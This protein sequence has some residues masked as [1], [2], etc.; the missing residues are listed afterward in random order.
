M[1]YSDTDR[2]KHLLSKELTDDIIEEI[3]KLNEGLVW[4]QIAKF[5]LL[6]DPEAESIGFESLLRAI[7]T[8][9][10]EK[11]S[12]FST[13]ATVCIY[14]SLGS[15][16][17]SLNTLI[18][19][20]TISYDAPVDDKGTTHLDTF[21]SDFDIEDYVVGNEKVEVILDCVDACLNEMTNETQYNIVSMWRKSDYKITY[22][23]IAT[24]LK[25]SQSYVSA[26]INKFR[27]RLKRKLK[28]AY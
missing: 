11:N 6:D 23:E 14:N 15:Y 10:A 22:R 3:I 20:N 24:T 8:F 12:R 9:D 7:N 26:T 1:T 21:E 17:R 19:T 25:C 18:R 28:E 2:T 5:G 13:Y 4:K 16:V 27:K